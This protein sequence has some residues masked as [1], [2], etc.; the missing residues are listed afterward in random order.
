M[1]IVDIIPASWRKPLYALLAVTGLALGAIASAYGGA[2]NAPE[3]HTVANNVFLYVAG[4]LGL[5]A[6]SNTV[7]D[8]PIT[9]SEPLAPLDDSDDEP[10]L[11]T[12][13]DPDAG[14]FG[15]TEYELSQSGLQEV[16]DQEILADRDDT[17][18]PAG[19]TP[20]H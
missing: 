18:P 7:A 8:T 12:D 14:E 17:P 1:T 16:L 6:A 15:P 11:E 10:A 9:G 5:L 13:S 19:Y 2:D 3:W 4:A 20:A